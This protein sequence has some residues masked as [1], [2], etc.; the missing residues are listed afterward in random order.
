LPPG[1]SGC[2]FHTHQ[3]EDEVFYV[4]SGRGVLRYGE[5]IDDIGAGDCIAC[6]AG[7]GIAH[8]LA[9]PFD[10]GLERRDDAAQG[11]SRDR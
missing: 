7:T 4:L 5:T 1:R 11:A 2:P 10:E 9:N 8:Q 3:R 6:P